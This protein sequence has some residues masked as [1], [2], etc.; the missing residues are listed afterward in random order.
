MEGKEETTDMRWLQWSIEVF[1]TSPKP[2]VGK[3]AVFRIMKM[4]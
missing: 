1:Q 3:V 2:N 4:Q